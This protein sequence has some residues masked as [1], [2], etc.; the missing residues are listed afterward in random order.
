MG[1]TLF[2]ERPTATQWLGVGCVIV[3]VIVLGAVA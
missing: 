2:A 3:G 1:I